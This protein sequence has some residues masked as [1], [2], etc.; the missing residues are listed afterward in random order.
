MFR[1]PELLFILIVMVLPIPVAVYFAHGWL[2]FLLK[3]LLGMAAGLIVWL[4]IIF[5]VVWPKF[6]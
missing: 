5:L 3:D 6:K 2:D 1:H 4:G